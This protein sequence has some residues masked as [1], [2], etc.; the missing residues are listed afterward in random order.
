MPATFVNNRFCVAPGD[1][2]FYVMSNWCDYFSLG[3]RTGDD[4]WLEGRIVDGEFVFNGRLFMHDG[5]GGTV[6]D[7]FPKADLPDGWTQAR[8][9]DVEGYQLRDPRGELVFAYSVDGPVCTVEVD[10]YSKSGD[11]A[12]HGGQGGMVVHVPAILSSK[13]IAIARA[14]KPGEGHMIT[15]VG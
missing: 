13:R 5:S 9:L 6:I 12:A 10:L 3:E 14:P 1:P 15:P 4:V 8:T 7:S 11:L 2:A